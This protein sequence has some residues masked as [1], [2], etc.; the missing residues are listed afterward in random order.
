MHHM[1][2][3]GS[4]DRSACSDKTGSGHGFN[5][6]C[7]QTSNSAERQRASCCV[8]FL[9]TLMKTD[10]LDFVFHVIYEN[11]QRTKFMQARTQNTTACWCGELCSSLGLWDPLG[12]PVQ[13][14][15]FLETPLYSRHWLFITSELYVACGL[16]QDWK[17]AA[18]SCQEFNDTTI[19]GWLSKV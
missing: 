2:Q 10:E 9:I 3:V 13:S 18:G 4:T 6:W 12:R 8:S 14:C 5:T 11:N 7:R 16:S 19:I 17:P 15:G 1:G